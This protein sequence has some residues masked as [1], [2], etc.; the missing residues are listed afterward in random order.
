MG[1]TNSPLCPVQ[2]I[3]GYLAVRNPTPGPLF[4]F[5]AGCPLTR[6]L[7]VAHLQSALRQAGIE[8]SPYTV[9]SFRIGAATTAARYGMEDSLIQTLGH[10][11]STAYLAYIRFNLRSWHRSPG[12]W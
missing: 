12:L 10:W 1:A 5:S 11:K 4:I 3:V 9:H 6:S 8:P 2:A 7:L